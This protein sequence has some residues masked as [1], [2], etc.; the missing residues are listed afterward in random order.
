MDCFRIA[1]YPAEYMLSLYSA[2]DFPDLETVQIVH[3]G[4]LWSLHGDS[5]AP[6]DNA[7]VVL[8]TR[9]API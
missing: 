3:F 9:N 8:P 4:C 6:S 2:G 5:E 1:I 7:S